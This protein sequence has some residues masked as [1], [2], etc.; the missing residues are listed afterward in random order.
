MTFKNKTK[1]FTKYLN[2]TL[3]HDTTMHLSSS[4]GL[5]CNGTWR[6]YFKKESCN[7]DVTDILIFLYRR[8]LLGLTFQDY[9]IKMKP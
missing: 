4:G 1:A 6:G 8:Y 2:G 7:I 3:L 5:S 9:I